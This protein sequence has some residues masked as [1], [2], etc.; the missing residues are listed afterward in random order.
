[1]ITRNMLTDKKKFD[2]YPVGDY[3]WSIENAEYV[4]EISK[5]TGNPYEKVKLYLKFIGGKLDGKPLTTG[6]F[7]DSNL[8]DLITIGLG[9]KLDDVFGKGDSVDG[10]KLCA[11]LKGGFFKGTLGIKNGYNNIVKVLPSVEESV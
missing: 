9:K 10:D 5:S 3:E 7:F 8:G 4:S 1:M 6:F 11:S 2:P